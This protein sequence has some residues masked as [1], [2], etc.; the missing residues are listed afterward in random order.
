MG[1]VARSGPEHG[2]LGA[3]KAVNYTSARD[4]SS[5]EVL[6]V[7]WLSLGGGPGQRRDRVIEL[8]RSRPPFQHFAQHL[9]QQRLTWISDQT[10][11]AIDVLDRFAICEKVTPTVDLS[12]R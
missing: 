12:V 7:S 5:V 9:I 4:A 10:T 8:L 3:F 11:M 2:R 1:V 6:H